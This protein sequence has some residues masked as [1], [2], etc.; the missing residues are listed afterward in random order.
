MKILDENHNYK[1]SGD[2]VYTLC[3]LVNAVEKEQ[4]EKIYILSGKIAE[5]LKKQ[6]FQEA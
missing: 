6:D 3:S 2:L 4:T 1:I 5:Q